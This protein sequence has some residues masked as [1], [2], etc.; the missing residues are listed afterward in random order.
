MNTR[1]KTELNIYV[2]MQKRISLNGGLVNIKTGRSRGA[3]SNMRRREQP[4][5]KSNAN[6]RTET[7]LSLYRISRENSYPTIPAIYLSTT[8]YL[9]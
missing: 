1:P 7:K 6:W 2:F 8:S 4:I 3:G 5:K 9:F